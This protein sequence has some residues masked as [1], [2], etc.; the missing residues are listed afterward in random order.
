MGTK[1][2]ALSSLTGANVDPAA[3][4]LLIDDVS[5]TTSKKIL[6]NELSIAMKLGA[7]LLAAQSAS[8]SATID[9]TA[10]LDNTYDG[11]MITVDNAKPENDD[12]YL[13]MRIG[14]GVGPTWQFGTGAYAYGANR[15]G[16]GGA[17]DEGNTSTLIPL[18]SILGVGFGV[19]SASGLSISSVIDFSNPEA[20]NYPMFMYRSIYMDNTNSIHGFNGIGNYGASTA[21]T[22]VRFF[23]STG[24]IASGTFRLYGLRKS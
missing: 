17:A 16:V 8:S 14:T 18:S 3:D 19:G 4:T 6:V 24:N 1:L 20:S 13:A 10:N 5:A 22:G 23:F 7:Q 9:F 2:S 11:Y 15:R 12:D 21:F